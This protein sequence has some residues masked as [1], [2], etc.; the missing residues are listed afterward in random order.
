MRNIRRLLA[1]LKPF[2]GLLILATILAGALTLV[3]MAPPLLMRRLINDVAGQGNWGLF[4]LIMGL[5]FG[6][7]LLRN[8]INVAHALTLRSVSLGIIGRTRKRL[9]RQMMRMSMPARR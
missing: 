9:F 6:V 3:G 2:R 1:F 4:P 8:T 5:M 7:P